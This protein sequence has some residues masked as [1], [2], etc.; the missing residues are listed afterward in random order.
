MVTPNTN[1]SAFPVNGTYPMQQAW[2][3]YFDKANLK[4]E[5]F[6]TI[7][8]NYPAECSVMCGRAFKAIGMNVNVPNPLA[9]QQISLIDAIF[10]KMLDHPHLMLASS[11]VCVTGM[12]SAT[13]FF[14]VAIPL[15]VGI[16]VLVHALA[17]TAILIKMKTS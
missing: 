9:V 4:P 11:C 10:S 13:V 16:S 17:L 1:P 5:E 12:L 14:L 3:L 7:E 6:Y 2:R 8:K 15:Y